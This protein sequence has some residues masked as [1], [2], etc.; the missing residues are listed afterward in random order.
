MLNLSLNRDRQLSALVNTLISSQCYTSLASA[1]FITHAC[2]VDDCIQRSWTAHH[3]SLLSVV[4]A[5]KEER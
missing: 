5:E 2:A 3:R 1:S 4:V